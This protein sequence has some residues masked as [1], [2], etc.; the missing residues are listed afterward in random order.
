[1]L[2]GYRHHIGARA[3]LSHLN[4]EV[5]G[6]GALP[7]GLTVE[8]SRMNKAWL[9]LCLGHVLAIKNTREEVRDYLRDIY[10]VEWD[11]A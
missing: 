1:V 5:I 2:I 6:M 7:N 9:V 4:S 8:W 3:R 10:G 11:H